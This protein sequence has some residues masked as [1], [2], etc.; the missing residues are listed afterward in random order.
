MAF[1]VSAIIGANA[2][3]DAAST[4]ANAANNAAQLQ[5][6]D[7]QNALGFQKQVYGNQVAATQPFLQGGTSAYANLLSLMGV[8][9]GGAPNGVGPPGATSKLMSPNG[10]QEGITATQNVLNAGGGA[11]PAD[12]AQGNNDL[13]MN[14]G[15]FRTADLANDNPVNSFGG[16]A[17]GGGQN[18]LALDSSTS[19]VPTISPIDLN[20]QV[21]PAL[22]AYGSLAQGWQ[23]GQFQAPTDVTEQNDPGFQFRLAQGQKA[24]EQSAAARGGLLSGGTAKALND[25]SQGQASNEY[26][27]VYSRALGQYQQNYNQFE[28]QSADKY[29]RL[30]NLAGMGQISAQQL[31]SA[32]SSAAG[33]VNNI[34]LTSGGQIGQDLNN[35]GAATASGYIG[36]ANAWG[37]ALNGLGSNALSL[38]S[39]GRSGGGFSV[40]GDNPFAGLGGSSINGS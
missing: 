7:A 13:A 12:P 30:A 18:S 29:N 25:Y 40:P 38:L 37:N 20:S 24:I 34:L 19:G 27:N 16:G 14:D 6:Q 10:S 33:G 9:P 21:N 17:N 11:Q 39:L 8:L 3:G 1:F 36:G 32:G 23:G 35:A 31:N 28:Q 4:Q 15:R 22:G 26:G 2:A 5:H